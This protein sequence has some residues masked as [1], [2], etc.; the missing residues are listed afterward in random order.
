MANYGEEKFLSQMSLTA[1]PGN[2]RIY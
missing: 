2:A 1:D